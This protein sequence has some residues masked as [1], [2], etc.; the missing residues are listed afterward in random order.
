MGAVRGLLIV[1]N[2]RFSS[3]R[4]C[5]TTFSVSRLGDVAL[6]VLAACEHSVFGRFITFITLYIFIV[7][8]KSAR[9]PLITWLLEAMRAPTPVRALVHSSTLVTVGV[10]FRVRYDLGHDEFVS[11]ILSSLSLFTIR[12]TALLAALKKDLKQIVALSTCNNIAWAL[13]CY[14]YGGVRVCITMLIIHGVSKC[15]LFIYSGDVLCSTYH[16]QHRSNFAGSRYTRNLSSL[17]YFV[18]ACCLI[19]FPFAGVYFAKHVVVSLMSLDGN[20]LLLP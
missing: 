17:F 6:F 16:R 8:T 5:C 1:Y 12:V 18:I 3:I 13:L 20:S 19:G 9:Y 14:I 2:C 4:A 11:I 7:A 10:W 15:V